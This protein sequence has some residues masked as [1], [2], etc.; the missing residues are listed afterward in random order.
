MA[1]FRFIGRIVISALNAIKRLFI[2]IVTNAEA[3]IILSFSA[4]GL[5]TILAEIP[6]HYALPAFLD[7]TM[8]IPV[9]SVTFILIL[10]TIMNLRM[11][12]AQECI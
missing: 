11:N 3:V 12:H 5:T 2:E 4:I 6:F 1:I 8:V 7:A 10:I 9:I